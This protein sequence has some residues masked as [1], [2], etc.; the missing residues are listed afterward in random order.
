MDKLKQKWQELQPRERML[1]S[2]GTL[3]IIVLLFY[4]G[5]VSPLNQAAN[6][7]KSTY[8]YQQNLVNWMRPRVQAISSNHTAQTPSQT[9]SQNELLPT[10]DSR[11]KSTTFARSVEQVTQDGNNNVRITFKAV[12]FDDLLTWL[13]TQWQTSRIAVSDIDVQ[14]GK[15]QGLTDVNLTLTLSQ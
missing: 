15:K 7:A 13:I 3:F 2:I 12:P 10:I 6:Q 4:Y 1:L 8:I 5:I 9:L 11:L 14:K